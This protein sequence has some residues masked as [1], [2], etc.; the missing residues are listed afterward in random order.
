MDLD[1][2]FFENIKI[3]SVRGKFY[4]KQDVDSLLKDIESKAEITQKDNEILTLKLEN[5]ERKIQQL[6]DVNDTARGLA[7]DIV[8]E[9]NGE[10]EKLLSSASAAADKIIEKARQEAESIVAEAE[11]RRDEMIN[12]VCRKKEEFSLKMKGIWDSF[13]EQTEEANTNPDGEPEDGNEPAESAGAEVSP[14]DMGGII[15]KIAKTI[16]EIDTE[17]N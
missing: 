16:T 15:E 4:R 17:E 8:A 13:L 5:I 6:G 11:G 2:S 10:A 14:E 3:E 12:E 7:Q 1:K 9:A